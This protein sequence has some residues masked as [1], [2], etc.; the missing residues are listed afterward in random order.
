MIDIGGG[1]TEYVV[2]RPGDDPE[3]HISTQMGS[4]R[5]TGSAP[6]PAM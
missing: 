6:E 2:G 5:F 3:F 1:S 4:V